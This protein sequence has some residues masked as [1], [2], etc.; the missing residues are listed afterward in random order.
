MTTLAGCLAGA[1]ICLAVWP[2]VDD[3]LISVASAFQP[4]ATLTSYLI[5]GAVLQWT[6]LAAFQV[7]YGRITGV[8]YGIR[9]VRLGLMC[10]AAVALALALGVAVAADYST[11]LSAIAVEML[12]V[13]ACCWL[14]VYV[15]ATSWLF[16]LEERLTSAASTED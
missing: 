10:G 2:W 3:R 8:N 4:A 5:V 14:G 15:G 1:L 9:R 11:A 16:T 6:G 7:R 13:S 12:A